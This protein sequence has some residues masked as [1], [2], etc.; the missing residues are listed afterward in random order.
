MASANNAERSHTTVTVRQEL[1]GRLKEL[2]PY[3]SMS[4]NELISEMADEYDQEARR[5]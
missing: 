5:E 1:Y 4:Y 3:E 2:K